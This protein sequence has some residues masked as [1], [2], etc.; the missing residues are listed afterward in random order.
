MTIEE[1]YR[2]LIKDCSYFLNRRYQNF[3]ISD[4][5]SLL[6]YKFGRAIAKPNWPESVNKRFLSLWAKR[7]LHD[8]FRKSVKSKHGKNKHMQSLD[9]IISTTNSE[10]NS[11]ALGFLIDHN[12]VLPFDKIIKAEDLIN[13]LDAMDSVQLENESNNNKY[14]SNLKVLPKNRIKIFRMYHVEGKSMLEIG[15]K[16][17]ITDSRVSYIIDET[18]NRIKFFLKKKLDYSHL[19]LDKYT[20]D[21]RR[22]TE[23]Y[24]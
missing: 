11:D 19:L 22:A 17:G 9:E 7:R 12:Y 13:I 20:H 10:V 2:Y 24:S 3:D 21:K 4:I 6:S 15:A 18:R 23:T 1:Q 16:F 8:E 5:Q 14:S